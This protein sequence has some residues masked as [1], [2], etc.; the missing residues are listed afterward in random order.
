MKAKALFVSVITVPSIHGLK[1][2]TT[3]RQQT[4]FA[5]ESAISELSRRQ[6]FLT[7]ATT[8]T[9]AAALFFPTDPANAARAKGAA[10]LDFE[11]YMRDLVSGNKKEG[12]ILPS[13][14]GPPVPPPRI[15]KGD[16]IPLLLNTECTADCIPVQAMIETIQEQDR[17]AARPITSKEN[18]TKDIQSRVDAIRGKTK[19][20]FFTKAPWNEEEISDQYFFDF[21][22]YALWKTAAEL[23]ENNENRDRFMRKIGHLLVAK[24][25]D[26]RILTAGA[27]LQ[28]QQSSKDTGVLVGSTPVITELLNVFKGSGYCKNFRIRSSDN[29]GA[30]DVDNLPVFDELDDESLGMVGTTNCLV[31][32]YEPAVLGASLQINGE[33]SRFAP[34]FIGTSLA[35]VWEKYG[36]I[37]STWDVFFVDPEYRPNPKDYFPNEQL[38]QI[39]LNKK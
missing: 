16:I 26:E 37:R 5:S 3:P 19:R 23:I 25:E 28:K 38:L 7:G 11:F 36:G 15:L 1:P 33:N 35:A 13:Q 31:S 17:T 14:N 27:S 30:A 24:L 4:P 18:I 32:I 34:D 20:S 10:E 6:L 21:T 12:S 9:A 2:S 22:A 8:A 29:D 39:T